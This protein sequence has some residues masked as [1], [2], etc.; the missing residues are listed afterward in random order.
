[1]PILNNEN[2]NMKTTDNVPPIVPTPK[3]DPA[4]STR[5]RTGKIARLPLAIREPLN[6]RMLDGEEGKPLVEWLNGLPEV[7]AIMEA[8]F[9]GSPIREQNLSEWRKGG[10]KDWQ[11]QQE[12]REAVLSFVEEVGGLQSAAKEG[13]TDLL[14][15]YLAAQT[16]LELKRLESVPHGAEPDRRRRELASRVVALRRGDL[17]MERLRLQRE[18]YGLRH[19]TKEELEAEFWK[20][21]EDNINRDEFCRRRCFTYEQREAAIDKILGITP[22]ERH[23]TVPPPDEAPSAPDP[24]CFD[25]ASSQ[26]DPT[27][28]DPIRPMGK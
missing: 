23:E 18:K 17:E 7:R 22:A 11:R 3:T 27:Q 21:A 24:S 28:S 9:H 20:W 15:F 8:Q 14:A 5:C 4:P 10:Y 12:A 13:L 19:K 25:P 2:K 1:M 16:A 6:Q 26:P